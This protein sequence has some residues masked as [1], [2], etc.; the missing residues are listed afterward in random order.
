M[1]KDYLPNSESTQST[2]LDG[3]DE[4]PL[5]T[6]GDVG[7]LK[8][9]L[10]GYLKQAQELQKHRFYLSGEGHPAHLFRMT[11]IYQADQ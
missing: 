10:Q 4:W 1:Q 7:H 2:H 6:D 11:G 5:A 8:E 3:T 9:S